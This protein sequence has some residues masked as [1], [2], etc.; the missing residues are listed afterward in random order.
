MLSSLEKNKRFLPHSYTDEWSGVYRIF[1]PNTP[2]D[3][4]CGKDPTGTLY[5]GLAGSRVRKWSIPRT[6]ISSILTGE[7]HAIKNKE[8]FKSAKVSMG[9]FSSRVGVHGER[10][11]YK[12]ESL[13]EAILAEGWLLACY[14]DLYGEYPPWKAV[15]TGRRNTLS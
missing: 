15:S 3:R 2:I 8:C 9:F 13:A 6:R 4:C 1:S 7:H 11:N 10:K 5:I 12:G 14:K